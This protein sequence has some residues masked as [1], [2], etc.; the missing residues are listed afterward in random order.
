MATNITDA[1]NSLYVVNI[2]TKTTTRRYA[3]AA[4]SKEQARARFYAECRGYVADGDVVY[5]ETSE[6]G[7]CRIA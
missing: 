1:A 7:I 2:I 5:I 3:V 6:S 4:D